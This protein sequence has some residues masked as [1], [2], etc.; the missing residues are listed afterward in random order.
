MEK[1]FWYL[2]LNDILMLSVVLVSP[3]LAVFVQRKIDLYRE[4]RGH[5]LWIFRTLMATRGNKLSLEHVQA[6]NSIELF[7]DYPKKDKA[8]IEKWNEYFDHINQSPKDTDKDYLAKLPVWSEKMDDLLAELLK[9]MGDSLG[10]NFD[11]VKI[12]RGIYVPR[13][14]GDEQN[15]HFLLRKGMVSLLTSKSSLPVKVEQ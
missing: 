3:F 15:D 12:K 5:R 11:K 2:T 13:G 9:V 1:N 14:H 4:K 10:Y 8:I 6:L 7:F